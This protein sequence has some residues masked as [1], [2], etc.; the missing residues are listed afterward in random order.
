MKTK[1][2]EELRRIRIS[3]GENLRVMADKLGVS[4]AFLSAVENGKKN[5]PD[6]VLYKLKDV[7]SLSIEETE[8]VKNA[9]LE[10][11]KTI[12]INLEQISDSQKSLA[13]CFARQ[14]TELDEETNRHIMDILNRRKTSD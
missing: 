5:L 12:S 10:S 2:G 4:S 14:F 13:V 1:I 6:G 7:Y 8:A 11:Q 3:A 9:A